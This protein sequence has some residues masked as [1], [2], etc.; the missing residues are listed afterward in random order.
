MN[1]NDVNASYVHIDHE[2]TLMY[3]SSGSIRQGT[4]TDGYISI[5]PTYS[6][7]DIY[8]FSLHIYT[9]KNRLL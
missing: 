9:F 8:I 6:T 7:Y 3:H 1:I 4:S 5:C 2:Q